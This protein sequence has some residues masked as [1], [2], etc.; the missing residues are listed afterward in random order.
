VQAVQDW[1]VAVVVAVVVIVAATAVLAA[2]ATT[3]AAATAAA[4]TASAAGGSPLPQH[5]PLHKH[6][7]KDPAVYTVNLRTAGKHATKGVY[8]T[9]E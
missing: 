5:Q 6:A 2:A 4:T 9:Q 8:C 3:T 1:L 7:R